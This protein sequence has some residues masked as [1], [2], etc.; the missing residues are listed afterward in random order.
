MS[1]KEGSPPQQATTFVAASAGTDFIPF[2][3]VTPSNSQK[4][5]KNDPKN[6]KILKQLF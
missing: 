4:L 5:A 3:L 1:D 2:H 6:W